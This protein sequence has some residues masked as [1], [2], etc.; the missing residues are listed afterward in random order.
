MYKCMEEGGNEKTRR[1]L[2]ANSK[3][4]YSCATSR[5]VAGSISIGVIGIFI[6]IILPAAL[7]LWGRPNL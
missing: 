3:L 6:D 5:K 2:F 7:W 4:G 1:S